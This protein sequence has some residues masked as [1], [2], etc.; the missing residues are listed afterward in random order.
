MPVGK[1][2]ML[3]SATDCKER[4]LRESAC[5]QLQSSRHINSL[6][7]VY[8]LGHPAQACFA[9]PRHAGGQHRRQLPAARPPPRY[10]SSAAMPGGKVRSAAQPRTTAVRAAAAGR[11]YRGPWQVTRRC[12]VPAQTPG[13][14]C[15]GRC[16]QQLPQ[17]CPE[18]KT[19]PNGRKLPS[20]GAQL[21]AL[22]HA[23]TSAGSSYR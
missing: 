17:V 18:P 20:G 8:A 16:T 12:H 9:R 10:P 4:C 2:C 6:S 14:R 7:G 1:R 21:V 22:F 3:E 23:D 13:T 19:T 11:C 15:R 5:S